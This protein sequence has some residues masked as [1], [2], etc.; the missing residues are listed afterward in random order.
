M[1]DLLPPKSLLPLAG[2]TLRI[3]RDPH[4]LRTSGARFH[5]KLAETLCK[6]GFTPCLSD[7]RSLAQ[8]LALNIYLSMLS[9]NGH[10]ARS[11]RIF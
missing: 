10:N 7:P 5:E 2:H 11:S 4:G 1:F 8:K 6:L 9:V 3:F